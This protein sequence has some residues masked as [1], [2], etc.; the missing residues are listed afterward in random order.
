MPWFTNIAKDTEMIPTS[1]FARTEGHMRPHSVVRAILI[2]SLHAQALGSC[3]AAQ[4]RLPTVMIKRIGL[5]TIVRVAP[6]G[7]VI[8]TLY[9]S[10]GI[11]VFDLT[12]A[13]TGRF[14]G[15]LERT[16]RSSR[17]NRMLILSSSG[18]V[19][20]VVNRDVRTYVWCCGGD[21]VAVVTGTYEEARGFSPT[22]AYLIDLDANRERRIEIPTPYEVMWA[23]FDQALYFKVPAPAG[24]KNV[25]RYDPRIGESRL[26][27]YRD[28]RFSPSGT[29]YL[30]YYPDVTLGPPGPHIFER[31][32]GREVALPD[33]ALGAIEGWVFDVG[34]YLQL[35]R[36]RYP[37]RRGM[38]RGP[39][40]IDGYTIYDVR[41]HSVAARI[42]DSIR[43]DIVAPAGALVLPAGGALRLIRRLEEIRQ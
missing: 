4:S 18:S 37:Q 23:S 24:S 17:T 15:V 1:G 31:E 3:A 12:I 6:D 21:R 39:E 19:V 43:T 16:A 29:F 38:I 13:P 20:R 41:R 33:P 2:A 27:E 26:T 35:K 8:D 34:D 10:S 25:L 9:R 30:H 14:I 5:T 22:G 28:L 36:A 40:V 11:D 42:Q 32:T 7:N